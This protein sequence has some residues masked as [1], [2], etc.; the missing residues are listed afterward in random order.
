MSQ[1]HPGRYELV[2]LVVGDVFVRKVRVERRIELEHTS[3]HKPHDGVGK[4]GLC[5]RGGLEHRLFRY[6]LARFCVSEAETATVDDL[7]V[8]DHRE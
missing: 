3:V 7:R 2:A 5:H 4:D 8:L 1:N 6:R